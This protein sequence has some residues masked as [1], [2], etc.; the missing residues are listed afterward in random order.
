[1]LALIKKEINSFFASPIGYLV[2]AVFLVL[3]GLFLWV[4]SG[5]FNIF[6]NGFADLAPFFELAP[7]V[8]IFL[9]PAVTMRSFSEEKRMGTL[10]LLLT[11]PISL[12]NIILGKYLGALLLILLALIP[13][14]LYVFTISDLG[15]PP[16]NWDLGSTIGSYIGLLFLAMAYTAIGIFAS[17]LSENQIVAFISAVLLCFCMYYAFDG[18]STVITALDISFFGMQTH[19]KSVARGVIDTR[20]TI[21]FISVAGLFLVFTFISLK[22]SNA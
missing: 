12:K 11:K 19:F 13:T 18:I 16:G 5:N 7:W 14:V 4:F 8:F 20:D 10:E 1:M 15:N 6:D 2:I 21:Y 9:I 17:T 22:R 3:N